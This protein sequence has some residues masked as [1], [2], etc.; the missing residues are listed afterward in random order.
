MKDSTADAAEDTAPLSIFTPR[1]QRLTTPTSSRVQVPS[2]LPRTSSPFSRRRR[3]ISGAVNVGREDNILA[4]GHTALGHNI[5]DFAAP[6]ASSGWAAR[7]SDQDNASLVAG[8]E[9]GR[10]TRPNNIACSSREINGPTS[11]PLQLQPSSSESV[12]RKKRPS[13]VGTPDAT[14]ERPHSSKRARVKPRPNYSF[15][16]LKYNGPA[17]QPSSPL[18]FSNTQRPRPRLPARFSSSEAAARMLSKAQHGETHVKTV[19]LARGNVS[20]P[21]PVNHFN[22]PT[23]TNASRQSLDRSSTTRSDSSDTGMYSGKNSGS[24]PGQQNLKSIGIIELFEQDERPTFIVDLSDSANYGPG[25]L[26]PAYASTSL[27]SCEGLYESIVGT[28]EASLQF[29]DWLLSASGSGEGPN[30]HFPTCQY[31]NIQWSCSTLRKTLRVVNG[32]LLSSPGLPIG[33]SSSLSQSVRSLSI[34]PTSAPMA[35]V[36]TNDYF[37]TTLHL[38]EQIATKAISG[39]PVPSIESIAPTTASPSTSEGNSG[40]AG[41]QT[42]TDVLATPSTYVMD[43]I[44]LTPMAPAVTNVNWFS[45]H[46]PITHSI[47]PSFDWTRLPVSDTMP[48]HIR[49]AHSIDWASTSLG[50][51]GTWGSDLRQMCNLIMASPHPAAMYWGDD[52]IAIYNEAYIMLAGQKHPSLMGQSYSVAWSEIW[53]D[54]KDVF[55]N[56]KLTGEATMKDDDGLFLKRSNYLEETY[57]SWSIVSTPLKVPTSVAALMHESEFDCI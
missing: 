19:S 7:V 39:I 3:T 36:E 18:F 27:R 34:G 8:T 55:A 28:S 23:P 43:G 15:E 38:Q 6:H 49:F 45:S 46:I 42:P 2:V 11:S 51:I 44:P 40:I 24:S 53:D 13:D 16:S 32:S 12:I 17:Q 30:T 22:S 26:H 29:K 21:G 37:G 47:S 14:S 54:V 31:A 4:L 50:P 10:K 35:G 48:P 56:A 5:A 52:L 20:T 57:F 33:A 9:P 41:H 1:S 25:P